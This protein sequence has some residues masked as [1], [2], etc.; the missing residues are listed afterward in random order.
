MDIRQLHYFLT[1]CEEGQITAAARRLHMAQPPLSLQLKALEEEL[2]VTLVKRGNRS[3]VL[4]DAGELLKERAKEILQLCEGTKKEVQD[5]RR[6]T[7]K[8]LSI[9]IVTSSHS[10]FLQK[11]IL[12]FHEDY[13]N[14][15]FTLK[16]GNTFQIMELLEKG[17]IEL[18]VV[19]TPF[20]HSRFLAQRISSDKMVAVVRKDR[21]PF[22]STKI[23]LE[24]LKDLPLIYYER[25][26]SLLEEL[27]VEHGFLPHVI[28]RNQDARTTLQW[29]KSGIGI[30]IVPASALAL[31]DASDLDTAEL[32]EER[33]YTD[34]MLIC[35]KDHYLSDVAATFLSYYEQSENSKKQEKV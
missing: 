33:L 10:V 35:M 24:Q 16:E 17:S 1:I 19:R 9:G 4:T 25:Y 21:N 31:V 23:R 32:C 5:A 15:T 18:G 11:G 13:P 26:E 14:T 6:K 3:I 27:F 29:A 12:H 34:I 8:N 7:K 28:C 20:P 2:G 30:G 22:T